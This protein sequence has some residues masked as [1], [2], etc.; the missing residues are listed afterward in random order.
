MTIDQVNVID[1]IGIENA[2]QRVVLTI[3]DHLDWDDEEAHYR[4]LT[5]KLNAYLHF[6]ESGE[7]LK[8]YPDAAGKTPLVDFVSAVMPP[9]RAYQFFQKA[10]HICE[11]LGVQL[12]SRVFDTK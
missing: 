2:T 10:R 11:P 3:I 4:A 1:A 9:K 8:R 7:L 6:I 5:N 12:R